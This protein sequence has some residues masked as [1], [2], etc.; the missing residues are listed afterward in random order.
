MKKQLIALLALTAGAATP[1]FAQKAGDNIYSVG[2]VSVSPSF[3]VGK[4]TSTGPAPFAGVFEQRLTDASASAGSEVTVSVGWLHMY[5]N[6]LGAELTLGI[7]PRLS[8]N[9]ATPNG[10]GKYHSGAAKADALTPAIVGKY[11]FGTPG[12]QIRP[13]VGLGAS[14]VS[15]DSISINRGDPEVSAFAGT[16]ASLKTSWA[17]VYNAGMVY[18]ISDRLSLNASVSYI[19]I[20][21]TVTFVGT[22]VTSTGDLKINT[23]DYIVRLGYRF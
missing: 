23:T 15:F 5:T 9:I 2:L 13:Y 7:P 6:N 3:S 22:G 20:K 11:F 19:P 10:V 8:M 16:S 17:P 12:Q 14:R 21:T 1:T 4:I 18:N